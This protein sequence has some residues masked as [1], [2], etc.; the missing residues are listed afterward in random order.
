MAPSQADVEAFV[1]D[2][3]KP[4]FVAATY[5]PAYVPADLKTRLSAPEIGEAACK[6]P[7]MEKTARLQTNVPGQFE[8]QGNMCPPHALT[9]AA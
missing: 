3:R 9:D 5:V 4:T 2:V 1:S 8:D 6:M 7:F